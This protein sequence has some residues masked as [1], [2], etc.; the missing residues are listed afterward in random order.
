MAEN[1][2]RIPFVNPVRF[3]DT[4]Q[5]AL[6]KYFTKHFDY[7]RFTERLYTWQPYETYDQIWQT[8]DIIRLQFESTMD[9]IIV[10][11]VDENGIAVI[12]LPAL[13]G[14]PNRFY[15]N[16]FS[17]EVEM[18][19]A[20]VNDGCYHLLIT[21]GSSGPQ[22]KTMISGCQCISSTQLENTLCLEYWNSRF[23]QDVVFETG[24]RFQY[25]VPGYFG[26]LEPGRKDELYRD[27]R[28]NPA[29][30]NSKVSRLWPV[31]FGDY[32]GLTDDEIDLLNRIWSC[33][34][35]LI[36]NKPFGISD[37]GKFEFTGE[38]TYP[39][40]GV[41]LMVEEGVNRNSRIF[42]I[43][44]DDT[45]KLM[46]AIVVDKK[47]WGDTSNQGSSNAVPILVVE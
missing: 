19:L 40:R 11:L 14:L 46:H 10:Q 32:R 28:Y 37:G 41:K 9:P 2:I 34:N 31:H 8:D 47:V 43:N 16:T 6:S 5:E 44:T 3:Y 22:Q 17:F 13:I 26:L 18:S 39:K 35:V 7:Y 1:F 25:R 29:L 21:A 30:L 4:D 42:Q 27:Q 36:D 45:K 20:G 23:A 24:I 38:E 15:P 12:T 33:D